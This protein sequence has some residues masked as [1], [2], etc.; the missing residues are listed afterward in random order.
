MEDTEELETLSPSLFNAAA[1]A[2]TNHAAAP[3]ANNPLSPS[4]APPPV[5][6]IAADASDAGGS[7]SSDALVPRSTTGGK[8]P[9]SAPADRFS[10]DRTLNPQ[11]RTREAARA[12][13]AWLED[14]WGDIYY[15]AVVDAGGNPNPYEGEEEE[16]FISLV[17]SAVVLLDIERD[18]HPTF[19][20]AALLRELPELHRSTWHFWFVDGDIFQY[21]SSEFFDNDA[22]EEWFGLHV[23]DWRGIV[24]ERD[25]VTDM[26]AKWNV[27]RRSAPSTP[28]PLNPARAELL[29]YYFMRFN[30]L[31][32]PEADS[33][34]DDN[35]K[36]PDSPVAGGAIVASGSGD[37]ASPIDE[38]VPPGRAPVFSLGHF[39]GWLD[40][41]LNEGE[42]PRNPHFLEPALIKGRPSLKV[43]YKGL[44][45]IGGSDWRE[46]K[47]V[48]AQG[49]GPDGK[50]KFLTELIPIKDVARKL[51]DQIRVFKEW[52]PPDPYEASDQVSRRSRDFVHFLGMLSYTADQLLRLTYYHMKS[53]EQ[54]GAAKSMN[55][56]LKR[57]E[58]P[59]IQKALYDY[60][61]P[62]SRQGFS[63]SKTFT[64]SSIV[65]ET[66]QAG[67]GVF[68]AL[69]APILDKISPGSNNNKQALR[70]ACDAVVRADLALR[71]AVQCD[72]K[73]GP[74]VDPN[75]GVAIDGFWIGT[76]LPLG[77]SD[78]DPL[79]V[80]SLGPD[81]AALLALLP[82]AVNVYEPYT[83]IIDAYEVLWQLF[84]PTRMVAVKVAQPVAGQS[85]DDP[86]VAFYWAQQRRPPGE[87]VHALYQLDEAKYR[88]DGFVPPLGISKE[89]ELP[90]A[91]STYEYAPQGDGSLDWIAGKEY[92]ERW[93]NHQLSDDP[94][95]GRRFQPVVVDPTAA[96]QTV[97]I[98]GPE[99][100]GRSEKERADLVTE[101][102][103]QRWKL[104]R[105]KQIVDE[106]YN[107]WAVAWQAQNTFGEITASVK[108]RKREE[109]R[110]QT[111][112]DLQIPAGTD[113]Q[114][115]LDAINSELTSL[116][117]LVESHRC[118]N[119][120][121]WHI[122]QT[123]TRD[124]IVNDIEDTAVTQ[125][126]YLK[127][128]AA[129]ARRRLLA[130]TADEHASGNQSHS[131]SQL[132]AISTT[133]DEDTD[134]KARQKAVT[135]VMRRQ[136]YDRAFQIGIHAYEAMV[137]KGIV[138]SALAAEAAWKDARKSL[139]K[140]KDKAKEG[141]QKYLDLTA[142]MLR[143]ERIDLAI[144][145]DRGH[146]TSG[147]N[148]TQIEQRKQKGE[149]P[150]DLKQY[151]GYEADYQRI[152]NKMRFNR[153]TTGRYSSNNTHLRNATKRGSEKARNQPNLETKYKTWEEGYRRARAA[154]ATSWLN[155]YEKAFK[156]KRINEFFRSPQ[157]PGKLYGRRRRRRIIFEA[158]R[159][160]KL[161]AGMDIL[162]KD[163]RKL[164]DGGAVQEGPGGAFDERATLS[165]T[166]EAAVV[167]LGQ[168]VKHKAVTRAGAWNPASKQ[169]DVEVREYK[170]GGSRPASYMYRVEDSRKGRAHVRDLNDQELW[171]LDFFR[172]YSHSKESRDVF[173]WISKEMDHWDQLLH[174]QYAT[175]KQINKEKGAGRSE[176]VMRMTS[177][178]GEYPEVQPGVDVK[179]LEIAYAR[180]NILESILAHKIS[181]RERVRNVWGSIA[182]LW[183]MG[184]LT[185]R[186]L[187]SLVCEIKED[188][189]LA[190]HPLQL[191][192]F[193]QLREDIFQ[194]MN[195]RRTVVQWSSA[196][197]PA[198]R[199][200]DDLRK[201]WVGE[202]GGLMSNEERA[203]W[204][205]RLVN[206]SSRLI[207]YTDMREV[208][209]HLSGIL[210][211][212]SEESSDLFQ[213]MPR[214]LDM[215]IDEIRTVFKEADE[216][217]GVLYEPEKHQEYGLVDE[218]PVRAFEP[219]M[220]PKY[221][222][223]V[224]DVLDRPETRV[225]MKRGCEINADAAM[226][227]DDEG[228]EG[229]DDDEYRADRGDESF[230]EDIDQLR[231]ELDVKNE[232]ISQALDR[233]TTERLT[234]ERDAIMDRITLVQRSIDIRTRARYT[235]AH[236]VDGRRRQPTIESWKAYDLMR[237]R[238]V[239]GRDAYG[240]GDQTISTALYAWDKDRRVESLLERY[241]Y[242]SDEGEYQTA[243]RA[244]GL[245]DGSGSESESD[246]EE[247]LGP[248]PGG[249]KRPERT[250]RS[251][252]KK[253]TKTLED[254]RADGKLGPRALYG[255]AD[256]YDD[257]FDSDYE[258]L[259]PDDEF[260]EFRGAAFSD[261]EDPE[262]VLMPLM[263][264]P[265]LDG[266]PEFQQQQQILQQSISINE[267]QRN[268]EIDRLRMSG[269]EA[270][271]SRYLSAEKSAR[272]LS[273]R[274]G[275]VA[276]P[277]GYSP[278]FWSMLPLELQRQ[279]RDSSNTFG[280]PVWL[281]DSISETKGAWMSLPSGW[282]Q[283]SETGRVAKLVDARKQGRYMRW[284]LKP[285][286]LRDAFDEGLVVWDDEDDG[287]TWQIGGYAEK[288]GMSLEDL[289][290]LYQF[291][292]E[293]KEV[294][295][296][297]EGRNRNAAAV[298]AALAQ[299]RKTREARE[300]LDMARVAEESRNQAA[301][302][303]APMPNQAGGSQFQGAA[304]SLPMAQAPDMPVLQ[305][306]AVVG[307]VEGDGEGDLIDWQDDGDDWSAGGF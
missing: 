148:A 300:A 10:E 138:K 238:N 249:G 227:E 130:S 53:V 241:G 223:F 168:L 62:R 303:P 164:Y 173:K 295:Y 96:L 210:R 73:E 145:K 247:P 136:V 55:A 21:V 235:T 104:A 150:A 82:D 48:V 209:V 269:G 131:L 280:L 265:V 261:D 65:D 185:A 233:V 98:T 122:K 156:T 134:D 13:D 114:T 283:I 23:T 85:I 155:R 119:V 100:D 121:D 32:G 297:P 248:A 263:N 184:F 190:L 44:D 105:V 37:V 159:F 291:D 2:A 255:E 30:R 74:M 101:L 212:L 70:D 77:D 276:A 230:L 20:T 89:P 9:M 162:D 186:K 192:I 99:H 203:D 253:S 167:L 231:D 106:Q 24:E 63:G 83:R 17:E 40:F 250:L 95:Y 221:A 124:D 299:L 281:P 153:L 285:D 66:G 152:K 102:A 304:G 175:F 252:R 195:W 270:A 194:V 45:R 257:D 176:Q 216:F 272:R 58:E 38:P 4:L 226:A 271:V 211:D 112:A 22:A 160:A 218:P 116:Q 264:D 208:M 103:L 298:D 46:D 301:L 110:D 154:G 26:M 232:D 302:P 29:L 67:G 135:I 225:F 294:N 214:Q 181:R 19:N 200:C 33:E 15:D 69:D 262:E 254:I 72:L 182:D 289:Q 11:M 6:P 97:A 220:Y 206:K 87:I 92:R 266:S 163:E 132:R 141:W 146:L 240:K 8:G 293:T 88:I 236:L 273:R 39:R 42:R 7:G 189:A 180:R 201:R 25:G 28:N 94:V 197:I 279:L 143:R 237:R 108:Q 61:S 76:G 54:R 305:A 34:N 59:T 126:K 111:M 246:D 57:G 290:M 47:M 239:S 205:K 244:A 129:Q 18:E 245:N 123:T 219:V 14:R 243:L 107:E 166:Q 178:P 118:Y 213:E 115:R 259:M 217:I 79:M 128:T 260:F 198:F 3:A 161:L 60:F 35:S 5:A 16:R 277:P 174:G 307:V 267:Q 251:A 133:T 288:Y 64:I 275:A 142:E 306:M 93:A 170:D 172:L 207:D 268:M 215:S 41:C 165:A 193:E 242:D 68:Q 234:R 113:L 109:F 75:T 151:T 1:A 86:D 147:R 71:H 140:K 177:R 81:S 191:L 50:M 171:V 169:C 183:E 43:P 282:M 224:S 78:D 204:E 228:E 258:S 84:A 187:N 222:R 179:A 90:V 144:K 199:A 202:Q 91:L 27:D 196:A 139:Q 52:L 256:G 188:R 286:E 229:A 137:A 284:Q 157:N 51:I 149:L 36:D 292:D 49:R 274:V 31:P 158:R 287:G 117:P 125:R 80:Q 278:V 127:A 56:A 120:M 12:A 296:T